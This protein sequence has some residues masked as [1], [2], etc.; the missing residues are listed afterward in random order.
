MDINTHPLAYRLTIES[1]RAL[2]VWT[3]LYAMDTPNAVTRES[4]ERSS[5]GDK[6]DRAAV[7]ILSPYA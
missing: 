5:K 7:A 3:L 4:L 6:Y 2:M 1:T